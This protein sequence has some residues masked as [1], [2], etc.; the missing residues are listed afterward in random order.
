[1][2]HDQQLQLTIDRQFELI[3]RRDRLIGKL[4][5]LAI[6]L[7]AI[8]VVLAIMLL[9]ATKAQA[10]ECQV[11][12]SEKGSWTWRYVEPREHQR[13]WYEGRRILPKSHLHWR[14]APADNKPIIIDE[15]KAHRAEA[16]PI[17]ANGGDLTPYTEIMEKPQPSEVCC[18]PPLDERTFK[19]R[20]D[21]L[22]VQWLKQ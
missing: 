18:W 22:P 19:S 4:W 1:M 5:S 9:V 10:I 11:R 12:P 17:D 20:W 2:L 16:L 21:E 13:C 6:T 8:V 3:R 14:S 15:I 7:F